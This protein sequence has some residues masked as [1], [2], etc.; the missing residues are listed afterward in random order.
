MM[1]MHRLD[2]LSSDWKRT[3]SPPRDWIEKEERRRTF[4]MTFCMDR[5][6]TIGTGWPATID[7]EDV[8]L[9]LV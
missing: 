9:R 6:A 2:G 8:S 1:G 3:I 5:Y 7:E 4:W